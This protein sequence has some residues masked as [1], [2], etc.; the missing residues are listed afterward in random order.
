MAL[1]AVPGR[2]LAHTMPREVWRFGRHDRRQ[3][4][5]GLV[6]KQRAPNLN[7]GES[8][9]APAGFEAPVR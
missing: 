2:T 8:R 1:V 7:A 6:N 4:G 5:R 9:R 3:S